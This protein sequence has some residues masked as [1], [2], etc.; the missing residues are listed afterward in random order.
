MP[1]DFSVG[2]FVIVNVRMVELTVHDIKLT[3]NVKNEL[4]N[5]KTADTIASSAERVYRYIEKAIRRVGYMNLEELNVKAKRYMG[6]SIILM[7][8]FFLYFFAIQ[9]QIGIGMKPDSPTAI[10]ALISNS[11]LTLII[12]V[13]NINAIMLF[14]LLKKGETPF[15]MAIVRKL[16]A[17]SGLLISIEPLQFVFER[18]VNALSMQNPVY[19]EVGDVIVYGTKTYTSYGGVFLIIG[20]VVAC[21]SLAFEYGVVLQT[22]ADETL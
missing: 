17:I 8:G 2:I 18:I 19:T 7:V 3:I 20:G 16:R 9:V 15:Q 13:S 5:V 4:T 14:R 1:T 6:L 22:Q 11:V 10:F 21:V 12:V